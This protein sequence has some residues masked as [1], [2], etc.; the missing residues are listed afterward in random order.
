MSVRSHL[1]WPVRWLV[2]ALVL[3]FS[4]AVAMW[5]YDLGRSF[6][7]VHR[8]DPAE[9]DALKQQLVD[10]RADL[11]KAR[12][13]ASTAESLLTAE[14]TTQEQLKAQLRQVESEN[15]ALKADLGFFERLLPTG[16]NQQLAVRGFQVE[17]QGAGVL[18]YQV[19]AMQNGRPQGATQA[20]LEL[21]LLGTLDGKPWKLI[22]ADGTR[23]ISVVQYA[24]LDGILQYPVQA[25]VKNVQLRLM[26]KRGNV[27]TTATAKP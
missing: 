19:L 13:I 1:P 16:K 14:K 10:L 27:I 6:A 24:R 3:G 22:T 5:A 11:D 25:S 4:G 20:K 17:A 18:R 21:T 23:D 15:L 8:V 26:D 7:G 12:S 2:V 9:V